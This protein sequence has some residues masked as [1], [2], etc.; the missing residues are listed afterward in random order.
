M[1]VAIETRTTTAHPRAVRLRDRRK[2]TASGAV[3]LLQI[4]AVT[5]YV[6]P[7]DTVI[8]AI[9]ASGYVAGLVGL[10]VFAAW[11]GATAIGVHR[12][13]D[14]RHPLRKPI[15]CFWVVGLVSYMLMNRE[16]RPELQLLSADRWMLQL[17]LITGV[18]FVAAEGLRSL[19]DVKRVLRAATWGGAFCGG[20]AALQYWGGNDVTPTLRSLPGFGVTIDNAA[21]TSREAVARVAGTAIHPIELGVVAGMLLPLALF[22]ALSDGDRHWPA[23]GSRSVASVW[24]SRSPC[25][26]RR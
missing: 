9:G 14:L 2:V 10:L 23:L 15:V 13:Q 16:E 22:L 8:E 21:I 25:R 1:S 18:V 19:S 20:V 5:L 3:A 4:F 6:F 11:I 24:P 17:A 7:S 26:A 12:P